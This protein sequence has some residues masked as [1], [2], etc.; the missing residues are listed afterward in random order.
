MSLTAKSINPFS[1]P[2]LLFSSLLHSL[3]FFLIMMVVRNPKERS[4]SAGK[5]QACHFL[6]F[7]K[8]IEKYSDLE[9]SFSVN[10]SSYTAYFLSSTQKNPHKWSWMLKL[11]IRIT[12][13][14]SPKRTFSLSVITN[15]R[16]WKSGGILYM[17][18]RKW[19][20]WKMTSYWR[21]SHTHYN[22]KTKDEWKQEWW[23]W[24]VKLKN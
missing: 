11:L 7:L 14:L 23:G 2:S 4:K 9:N 17:E 5:W 21:F 16:R 19:K 13:S 20:E 6:D 1:P 12:L 3:C 18:R 24:K 8:T 10:D 22:L 15:L